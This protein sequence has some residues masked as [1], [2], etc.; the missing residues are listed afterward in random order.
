M[1]IYS[2]LIYLWV[3]GVS[4]SLL[5]DASNIYQ[6]KVD[7]KDV[8]TSVSYLKSD[9]LSDRIHA[10]QA[11]QHFHDRSSVRPLYNALKRNQLASIGGTEDALEKAQLDASIFNAIEEITGLQLGDPKSFDRQRKFEAISKV[12]EWLK[13]NDH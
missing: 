12:E 3:I 8:A 5:A 9:R 7:M 11:L 1:K 13:T 4:Y 10:A 6:N 2:I